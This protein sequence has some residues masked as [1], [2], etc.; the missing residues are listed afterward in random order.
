MGAVRPRW[1]QVTLPPVQSQGPEPA[2]PPILTGSP[3]GILA[4]GVWVP[5]GPGGCPAVSP[6][7]A[8]AE[9]WPD[10]PRLSAPPRPV[11]RATAPGGSALSSAALLW[12][13]P[14][15]RRRHLWARSATAKAPESGHA[16]HLRSC[17]PQDSTYP[18]KTPVTQRKGPS[19]EPWSC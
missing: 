6:T 4:V 1:G 19:G 5:R 10:P 13:S 2:A 8:S 17:Q 14:E 18:G 12:P 9:D 16:W 3:A 7:P 11:T 15:L